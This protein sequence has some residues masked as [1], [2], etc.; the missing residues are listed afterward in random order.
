[1]LATAV[2]WW[3][4]CWGKDQVA[5]LEILSLRILGLWDRSDQGKNFLRKIQS[6]GVLEA[7]HSVNRAMKLTLTCGSVDTG[8]VGTEVEQKKACPA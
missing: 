3:T 5:S 2:Q 4:G 7:N 1:M 8:A 6:P